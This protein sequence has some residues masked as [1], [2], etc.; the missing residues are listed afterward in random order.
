MV[1][2]L[3]RI[4]AVNIDIRALIEMGDLTCAHE[5]R[6]IVITKWI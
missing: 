3:P 4:D 1:T 6:L 2:H 5:L